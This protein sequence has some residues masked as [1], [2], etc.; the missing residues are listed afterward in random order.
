MQN[1]LVPGFYSSKKRRTA[2][3]GSRKP[4]LLPKTGASSQFPAASSGYPPGGGNGNRTVIYRSLNAS[5]W[6]PE[7]LEIPVKWSLVASI[8]VTTGV[9]TQVALK[10]NSVL[11][12]G[13]AA[14]STSVY[15]YDQLNTIYARYRVVASAIRVQFYQTNAAGLS[16]QGC[17]TVVWPSPSNGS[18]VSDSM[19]ALQQPYS[20]NQQIMIP[21][22]STGSGG[23]PTIKNYISVAKLAGVTQAEVARDDTYSALM[24][25]DPTKL[26]Y[27]VILAYADSGAETVTLR[28]TIELVQYVHFWERNS[29]AST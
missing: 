25:G 23:V 18:F 6:I 19:G 2:G 1:G 5:S 3:G 4:R 28:A 17:G 15:G 16:G 8:P 7:R 14:A 9:G 27:W 24:N 20:K 13:G 10:M 21:Y 26:Y 11:D 29:L 12:P 22:G